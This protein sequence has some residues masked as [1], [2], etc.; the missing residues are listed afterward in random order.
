MGGF[1]LRMCSIC[2]V[3]V[4]ETPRRS[5][6]L[7]VDLLKRWK[8]SRSMLEPIGLLPPWICSIELAMKVIRGV[9][10]PAVPGPRRDASNTSEGSWTRSLR[11]SSVDTAH[12]ATY[13]LCPCTLISFGCLMYSCHGVFL[14]SV[15]Q[16]HARMVWSMTRLRS[17]SPTTALKFGSGASIPAAIGVS[18]RPRTTF[19]LTWRT[20]TCRE[21]TFCGSLKLK[22]WAFQTVLRPMK[23]G[24][25]TDEAVRP[26]TAATAG[27]SA[28][29]ASTRPGSTNSANLVSTRPGSTAAGRM[30]DLR[31]VPGHGDEGTCMLPRLWSME[32]HNA[33]PTTA[34][35]RPGSQEVA[36]MHAFTLKCV[37][38]VCVHVRM[39][40]RVHVVHLCARVPACVL[41][42]TS[43][44]ACACECMYGWQREGAYEM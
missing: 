9:G 28:T 38:H 1:L 39:P 32:L 15:G 27:E 18:R 26:C 3:G 16:R 44:N 13:L 41:V 33:S 34:S 29:S 21:P 6:R 14:F 20:H 2:T 4:F 17:V 5:R 11:S 22:V 30:P 25:W 40:M 36:T 31:P 23:R 8:C 42:C 35:S 12:S 7:A 24:G 10:T 19:R 43:A 37:W